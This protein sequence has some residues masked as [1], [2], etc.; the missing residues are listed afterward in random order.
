ME[1][2]KQAYSKHTC[3]DGYREQSA[4]RRDMIKWDGNWQISGKEKL[5]FISFYS[6]LYYQTPGGI[7]KKQ[8]GTDTTA[9]PRA[10]Q[11]KAAI[12][13]KTIFAGVSLASAISKHFDNTTAITANHT[14]F[15]NPFTTN[16]ELRDEWNEGGRT[17][18]T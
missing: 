17:F 1:S 13:N 3:K 5:T 2:Y 8:L 6:D 12:Y 15:K 10:V 11:Q 16:Y 9:Y 14:S 7:T 4:M 18:F